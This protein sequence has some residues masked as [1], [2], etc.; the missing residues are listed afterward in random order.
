[1]NIK[2]IYCIVRITIEA[3]I[4]NILYI[5]YKQQNIAVRACLFYCI[6]NEL[7]TQINAFTNTRKHSDVKKTKDY[8]VEENN[9]IGKIYN[10]ITVIFT[11][12]FKARIDRITY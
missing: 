5:I 9:K 7:S 4:N 3:Y 8:W 1:M 2:M 11:K 12:P 6:G 10:S